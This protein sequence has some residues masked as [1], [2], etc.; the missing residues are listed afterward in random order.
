MDTIRTQIAAQFALA[1]L[2]NPDR[3]AQWDD[4][5]EDRITVDFMAEGI[6]DDAVIFADALLARLQTVTA[7]S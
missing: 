1:I 4:V 5:N 2:A 6:A 7:A 3:Q